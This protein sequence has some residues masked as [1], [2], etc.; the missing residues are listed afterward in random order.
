MDAMVL[1]QGDKLRALMS[2]RSIWEL[3]PDGVRPLRW[4]RLTELP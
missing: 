2:D 1:L 3:E 4:E